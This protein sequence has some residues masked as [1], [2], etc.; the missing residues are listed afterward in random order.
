MLTQIC[1]AGFFAC[2]DIASQALPSITHMS[3]RLPLMTAT[4]SC[5]VGLSRGLSAKQ[6]STRLAI[7]S[8][9]S[10][11]TC[12]T[13]QPAESLLD[14]MLQQGMKHIGHILSYVLS[15]QVRVW[16]ITRINLKEQQDDF[17]AQLVGLTALPDCASGAHKGNT[18]CHSPLMSS[19]C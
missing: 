5:A 6:R 12:T 14:C 13:T 16:F 19:C 3:E 7:C 8:G 1:N 2:C 10:S 4:I 18:V 17:H 9:H 15:G 11:G